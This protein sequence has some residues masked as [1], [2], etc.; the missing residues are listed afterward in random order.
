MKNIAVILASGSGTRFGAKIPKQFV[1]L[2]GKP[3]IEYTIS[4]FQQAD[5][6]HEIII[7]CKENYVDYLYKIINEKNFRKV[8]KVIIGGSQRYDSTWAAINAITEYKSNVIIHDAVRPFVTEDIITRC[9]TALTDFNAVNVVID[10]NDTIVVV[11]NKEVKEIPNRRFLKRGQTPQAFK[12]E[13]LRA[14]YECF[15]EDCEKIA[16]DDC[17]IVKKYLPDEAIAIIEGDE[18][19]FKITHQQ[20][21]Y[22]ADNLI[23]DG[24]TRSVW[25]PIGTIS[26]ALRGKVV[27]IVGASSGIGKDLS[28]L[29][30]SFGAEVSACSRTINAVDVTCENSLDEYFRKI[31]QQK[32]RIDIIVN[33]T[34]LLSRKPFVTMSNEEVRSAYMVNYVGV[35]NVA[36]AGFNFLKKSQGMLINFTSSSYTRGRANYSIYSSAKAAVVN[37]TQALAEEWQSHGIRVNVINP[38]RTATPMRTANF[39]N[40]PSETLLSS[41]EVAKFTVSAMIQP[42]SGQVYSIKR[43]L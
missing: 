3:V 12:L 28:R 14:A 19:N 7:V 2:A 17:G 9:I 41:R 25:N 37:F 4:A 30:E 38:E 35:L 16:S 36:R 39:G 11:E 33:T 34:G 32:G 23:K 40:E 18:R 22:F 20:D 10:C 15:L 26:M 1:R 24:F 43:D 31:V 29:C 8:S 13:T 27:V 21:I 6:I 42:Y 5:I